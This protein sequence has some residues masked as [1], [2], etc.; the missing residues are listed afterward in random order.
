MKG[1]GEYGTPVPASQA[2]GK[3]AVSINRISESELSPLREIKRLWLV[4]IAENPA[5]E[6]IARTVDRGGL[7]LSA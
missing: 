2:H 5:T 1:S 7:L 3:G 6:A 4:R